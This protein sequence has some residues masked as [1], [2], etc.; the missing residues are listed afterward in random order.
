M[1]KFEYP[2]LSLLEA[3]ISSV[4]ADELRRSGKP[5]VLERQPNPYQSSLPSEIVTCKF[6]D[7]RTIQLFLKYDSPE[8]NAKQGHWYSVTHEAQVYRDILRFLPVSTPVYHG[9]WVNESTSQMCLVVQWLDG[10]RAD[11][12]GWSGLMAASRWLGRFHALVQEKASYLSAPFLQTFDTAYYV[13]WAKGTLR[14]A[15]ALSEQYG[16]LS[17]LCD[18]FAEAVSMMVKGPMVVIHGEY[19][20]HNILVFDQTVYPID[21]QS[22]AIARGELDLA[23]LTEGWRDEAR[24]RQCEQEYERSRWPDTTPPEFH[25]ALALARVY[26]PLRWLGSDSESALSPGRRWY[27]EH[28]RLQGQRAGLL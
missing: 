11:K 20:P 8:K 28:M 7:G 16:W 22:A 10:L 6:A 2:D 19:Y 3:C 24:I 17:T 21:W 25:T 13:Q 12:A 9:T 1:R 5:I 26:W 18:R 15:G 23:S 4:L 27:F 14:N